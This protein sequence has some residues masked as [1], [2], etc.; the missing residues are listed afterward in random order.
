ML[1]FLTCLEASLAPDGGALDPP[2]RTEFGKGKCF[3]RLQRR[4]IK[5]RSNGNLKVVKDVDDV[6]GVDGAANSGQTDSIST[7]T[8]TKTT[9][10]TA[11]DEQ[12]GDFVFRIIN[13]RSNGI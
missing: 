3:P 4:S 5:A 9:A 7:T 11:E 10:D 12:D 13:S 6:A 8:T 2:L 1:Q